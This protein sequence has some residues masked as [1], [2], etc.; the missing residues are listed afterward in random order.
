MELMHALTFPTQVIFLARSSHSHSLRADQQYID[1]VM[2]QHI[3][4]HIVSPQWT[5]CIIQ[6]LYN[7]TDY[8]LSASVFRLPLACFQEI[9]ALRMCAGVRGGGGRPTPGTTATSTVV[10]LPRSSSHTLVAF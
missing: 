3:L 9:N 7:M 1:N 10:Y 4:Q 2:Q 5:P 8:S 6:S